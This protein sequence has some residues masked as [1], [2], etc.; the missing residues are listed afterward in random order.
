MTNERI[1]FRIDADLKARFTELCDRERYTIT[2]ALIQYMAS[3]IEADELIQ[4]DTHTTTHNNT[5]P[6]SDEVERRL[7]RLEEKCL[8]PSLGLN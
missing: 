6:D 3:C 8:A 4:S 1:H 2:E 7:T 5:Q